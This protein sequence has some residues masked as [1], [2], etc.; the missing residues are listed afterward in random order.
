[1]PLPL[2]LAFWGMGAARR[3][4]SASAAVRPLILSR[5]FYA[6][7]ALYVV[8]GVVTAQTTPET[9][10]LTETVGSESIRK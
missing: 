10:H 3:F 4:H 1:M 6:R 7:V 5:V 2:S 8:T 9:F